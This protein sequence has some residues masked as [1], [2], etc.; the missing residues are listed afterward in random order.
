M[1]HLLLHIIVPGLVAWLFFRKDWVK[2][3]LIMVATYLVDLDHLLATP[4]Y[5]PDRCG[6][7]FHPLHSYW[8]IGV[9]FLMLFYKPMRIVALG[10]LIHMALDYIDC[11]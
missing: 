3:S 1:L 6:I 4:M 7:G 2:V 9:Y 5:D 11:F 8:A 10:L